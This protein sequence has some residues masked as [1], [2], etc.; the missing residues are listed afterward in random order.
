MGRGVA[1]GGAVAERG[2]ARGVGIGVPAGFGVGASAAERPG[3]GYGVVARAAEPPAGTLGGTGVGIGEPSATGET[4]PRT[5]ASMVR[6]GVG[7]GMFTVAMGEAPA[8]RPQPVAANSKL[9]AP[10]SASSFSHV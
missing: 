7:C 1:A 3:A 2:P 9:M 10:A 5:T 6:S 4:A 8:G